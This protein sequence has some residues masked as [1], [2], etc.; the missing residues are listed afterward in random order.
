MPTPSAFRVRFGIAAIFSLLGVAFLLSPGSAQFG[1]PPSMPRPPSA[2]RPPTFTQPTMPKPPTFTPPPIRPPLMPGPSVT[3][4]RWTCE[5]CKASLG[6]T[7]T[8]NPPYKQCPHCGVTF[9][10]TTIS[11]G[12]GMPPSR[13]PS[14]PVVPNEPSEPSAPPLPTNPN[15]GG[16]GL[17]AALFSEASQA[18]GPAPEA[19]EPSVTANN[20]AQSGEAAEEPPKKKSRAIVFV[21]A[22]IAVLLVFGALALGFVVVKASQPVKRKRKAYDLDDD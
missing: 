12:P 10:G 20:D 16:A 3:V 2:P 1:R 22:G 17:G 8:P 4:Y 19:S 5:R 15:A 6:E 13:P 9:T 7:R 18:G 11:P 14:N 21:I